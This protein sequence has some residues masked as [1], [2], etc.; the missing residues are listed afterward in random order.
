MSKTIERRII[1]T[2]V[3]VFIAVFSIAILAQKAPESRIVKSSVES[4]DKS[5]NT[6]LAL[7]GVT[8]GVATVVSIISKDSDSP[9]VQEITNM[10]KYFV[11]ILIVIFIERL[12][13]IVGTTVAF[14]FVIPA[15]CV[16][17]IIAILV[18]SKSF[19]NLAVK[20]GI[21]GLALAFVVPAGTACSD[22]IC[23]EYLD[24]VDETISQS[25]SV[26][27]M[28]EEINDSS[29]NETIFEKIGSAI[30]TAVNSVED[31]LTY[32]KNL[33]KRFINS[34]AILLVTTFLIPLII[35]LFG[36]WLL[37]QLFNLNWKLPDHNKIKH[38]SFRGHDN[39]DDFDDEDIA[40]EKNVAGDSDSAE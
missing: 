32:F 2:L 24:Y 13:A 39:D 35:A 29:D 21:L 18:G 20:I 37:N 4:L 25:N 3:L 7:T 23:A 36:I 19:R 10:D 30:K 26:D 15:A 38:F 33:V 14:K 28:K 22:I 5:K 6:V 17:G 12:I 11:F 31:A 16:F 1:Q 9:I 27:K 40:V 34:I 8:V